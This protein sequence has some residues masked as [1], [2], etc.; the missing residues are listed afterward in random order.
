MHEN[1]GKEISA[2]TS[3]AE[4]NR[5]A[6]VE[7]EAVARL[8]PVGCANKRMIDRLPECVLSGGARRGS[9]V[10]GSSEIGNKLRNQLALLGMQGHQATE[11]ARELNSLASIIVEGARHGRLDG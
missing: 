7:T 4:G 10:A 6:E 11:V 9:H 2:E 8:Q 1:I 5:F 3:N